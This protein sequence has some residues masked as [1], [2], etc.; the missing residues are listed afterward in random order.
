LQTVTHHNKKNEKFKFQ[1]KHMKHEKIKI[2]V[3]ILL[4]FCMT[5]LQAQET[6]PVSGGN[7]TGNGGTVSYSVG[8]M[9]YTSNFGTNGSVFQG[10]QQPFEISEITGIN[11]A[12]GINLT[13]SVYPNPTTELLTLI[14]SNFEISNLSYQLY[15]L[16]GKLEETKKIENNQINIV[17]SNLV[18]ATYFLKII[19]NK[20][21]IKLFKIIKN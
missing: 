11:E 14:I 13:A 2:T 5:R 21:E 17:V 18:P 10:V 4:C 20:T 12:F 9:V 7:A 3:F 15:D 1:K 8:Q 16:N 19:Q 6:I